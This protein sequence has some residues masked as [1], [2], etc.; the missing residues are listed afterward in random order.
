MD[1]EYYERKPD[2]VLQSHDYMMILDVEHTC[3]EDGSIPPDEREI[4]ELGAVIVDLKSIK[5]I[6]EFSSLI[7]PQRH[8]KI[9]N[10]CSQLTGITQ[11]ELD[12]SDNFETVFSNFLNWY[13]ITS[14]VLFATWG[15]YDLVQINIDCKFHNLERFSP[16]AVLNLKKA[17]KNVNKLKKPVGLAKA[18]V[19]CQR[20]YEGSHHRALD[21]ATNTVKL[22]PSIFNTL[23]KSL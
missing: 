14:K 1:T 2:F 12:D 17:F 18:L 19:L 5:I 13:P 23:E 8:P 7:K 20:E 3:T 10:F 4:I 21:D 16:N 9:S 6:D 22:L 15:S 11:S